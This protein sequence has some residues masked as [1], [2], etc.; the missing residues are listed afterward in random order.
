MFLEYIIF[1]LVLISGRFAKSEHHIDDAV[2]AATAFGVFQ[3]SGA[4]RHFGQAAYLPR[5]TP[6]DLD[7][8]LVSCDFSIS[9][10]AAGSSSSH[11]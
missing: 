8:L 3:V 1:T 2:I 5:M 9:R 4:P 6:P 10:T 7:E 11:T